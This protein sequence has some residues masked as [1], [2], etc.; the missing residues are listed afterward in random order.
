MLKEKAAK[1]LERSPS[2]KK[3]VRRV[4][5]T[6]GK[7]TKWVS[8]RSAPSQSSILKMPEWTFQLD[9][10]SCGAQSAYMVMSYFGSTPSIEYVSR[11]VHTTKTGTSPTPM[12]QYFR[13]RGLSVSTF[14]RKAVGLIKRAI[15]KGCP[16][17]TSMK[18]QE[19]HWVVVYGY[20]RRH[21]WILDP[22]M[23]RI[24]GTR[25]SVERFRARW[26]G[27]AM[28]ISRR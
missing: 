10:N 21:I 15:D 8:D 9:L 17:I 12:I 20:S 14:Q 22:A 4:A 27:Y 1:I 18:D 11:M 3:K 24:L 16:V 19:G 5:N 28:V 7:G 23:K 6:I 25:Q 2:V 26:D 13:S